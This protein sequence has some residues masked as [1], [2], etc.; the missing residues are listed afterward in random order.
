M[1]ARL[2]IV[3]I[4]TARERV[5]CGVAVNNMSVRRFAICFVDEI[6]I[7]I[8]NYKLYIFPGVINSTKQKQTPIDCSQME[9]PSRPAVAQQQ[10]R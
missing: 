6:I 3:A 5:E 8:L 7:R 4:L 9:S 2:R 10:T 1:S